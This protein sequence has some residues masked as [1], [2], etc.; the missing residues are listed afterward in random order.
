MDIGYRVVS[1]ALAL[2]QRSYVDG[3]V[4]QY[5]GIFD[6]GVSRREN[7]RDRN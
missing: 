1:T 4:M 5:S 3:D 6:R 7:N 2:G